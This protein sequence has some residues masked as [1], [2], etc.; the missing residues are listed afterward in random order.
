MTAAMMLAD[1]V[2]PMPISPTPRSSVPSATSNSAIRRPTPTD[3]QASSRVIAGPVLR[4]AVPAPD[5]GRDEPGARAGVHRWD[6]RGDAHVHDDDLGL[7]R[8]G[9]HID[10]GAAAEE[11]GDHLGRDLGRIGGHTLAGHAMVGCRDDDGPPPDRRGRLAG[12]A[13][14]IDDEL[15]QAA[16][17]AG[18]LGEGVEVA[19]RG[20]HRGRVQRAEPGDG[21]RQGGSGIVRCRDPEARRGAPRPR[22]RAADG[23]HADGPLTAMGSPAT[24]STTSSAA[25]ASR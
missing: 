3:R 11:V 13:G 1:V 8:A 14:Q 9:E 24:R 21:R 16:E 15:L 17:A 10:G 20:R 25:A 2:L 4:S 12:D 22:P 5:A 7:D 23:R 19:L 6:G 18:R